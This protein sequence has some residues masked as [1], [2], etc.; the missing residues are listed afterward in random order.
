MENIIRE[1]DAV[2][3]LISAVPV[4]GESVDFIAAARAKLRNIHAELTKTE[5]DVKKDDC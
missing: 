2:F 5:E 1:V 4:S 3:K